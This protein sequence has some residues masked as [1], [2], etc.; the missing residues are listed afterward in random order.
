M[1]MALIMIPVYNFEPS[2]ISMEISGFTEDLWLNGHM[3]EQR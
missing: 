1:R 2:V 3:I